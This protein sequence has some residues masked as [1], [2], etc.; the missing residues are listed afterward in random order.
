MRIKSKLICVSVTAAMLLSMTVSSFAVVTRFDD[1]KDVE[2]KDK[3]LA[4][5]DKGIVYGTGRGKFSPNDSVTAAQGVQFMVNAF[6]L[7]LNFV[8]FAKEPK[9]TDY[10]VKA[11]NNAWYARGLIIAAVNSMQL[12][13]DLDP[14]Q[15]WTREEFTHWL[16]QTMENH[17]HLPAVKLMYR[18]IA[19]QKEIT[20]EY[21]GEIQ[22]AL[23]YNIIKLDS[24]EKFNPKSEITRAEA[25]EVIFNALEY[26]EARDVEQKQK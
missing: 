14:A 7:N 25:A 9:A 18:E 19:D 26:I 4:L 11:D 12:P 24:K 16:V 20:P 2:V 23:L 5:K 10:F 17:Y 15:K 3:I 1:L 13:G 8:K 21:E 22:R 6:K